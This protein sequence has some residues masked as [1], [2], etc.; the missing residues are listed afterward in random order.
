MTVVE[1]MSDCVATR[2]ASDIC[3]GE[4]YARVPIA[5]A[6]MTLVAVEAI[7]RSIMTAFS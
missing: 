7:P 3:S 4:A 1:K 6:L 2:L 5:G